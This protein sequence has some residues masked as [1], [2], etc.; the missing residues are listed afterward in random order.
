LRGIASVSRDIERYRS[1]IAAPPD[2][3]LKLTLDTAQTLP[4]EL[5]QVLRNE[6]WPGSPVEWT[7]TMPMMDWLATSGQLRWV[8]RDSATHRENMNVGWRFHAGDL[9]RI[10]LVNDARILHPMQHPI[11]IH[12]QRFLVVAVDGDP[13]QNL[14]WKDTAGPGRIDGRSARRDDQSR[15]VDA[16]LPYRRTHGEWHAHDV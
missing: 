1:R 14:F 15:Q 16:A 7:G 9:V 12:G 4:F 5:W 6:V 10:R 8:L 13:M 2:Y 3:T 11:H